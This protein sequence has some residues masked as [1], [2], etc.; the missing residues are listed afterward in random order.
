MKQVLCVKPDLVTPPADS[1][2]PAMS[3]DWNTVG[4]LIRDTRRARREPKMTQTDLA[5][6]I[7]VEQQTISRIER[8]QPTTIATLTAICAVLG[9]E[10]EI[11]V[12]AET[13]DSGR[14]E[15][16][17]ELVEA[18]QALERLPPKQKDVLINLL[19]V[20]PDLPMELR[21][22]MMM[23]I[24]YWAETYVAESPEKASTTSAI[25]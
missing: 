12:Q 17:V 11:N 15:G 19:R 24:R 3:V 7:G 13:P 4:D 20:F 5:D 6:A 16:P 14:Y 9:L 10:L 8:G 22:G 21:S 18:A 25:V 23:Q 1:Q 2:D